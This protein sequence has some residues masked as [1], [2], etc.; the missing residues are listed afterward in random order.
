MQAIILAAGVGSRLRPITNEV[1]KCL[2][3]VNKKSIIEY[4]IEAYLNAGI[5]EIIVLT[6]Y[7]QEKLVSFLKAKYSSINIIFVNNDDYENTNN[8]YSLYLARNLVKDEFIMSNADVVFSNDMVKLLL[9][10]TEDSMIAVDKDNY[11][12]ESMKIIVNEDKVISIS[13]QIEERDAY[14]T[15]IDLYKFNK[16]ATKLMFNEINYIINEDKNLNSWTEVA[17]DS[18]L[19]KTVFKPMNIGERFWYEIDNHEDLKLAEKIVKEYSK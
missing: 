14:G 6:G 3:Q 8:M 16:E 10:N 11:N 7:L 9:Q 15:S 2:V 17:L 5:E 19:S 13:K 12:E 1:P 4:Q 18:I